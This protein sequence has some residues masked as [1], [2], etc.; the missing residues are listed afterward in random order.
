MLGGEHE[1]VRDFTVDC[2]GFWALIFGGNVTKFAPRKALKS[3][4]PG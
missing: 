2:M 4:A 3:I 1:T